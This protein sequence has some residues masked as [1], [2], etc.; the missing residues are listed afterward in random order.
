ML[1]PKH[2]I[3][4]FALGFWACSENPVACFDAEVEKAEVFQPIHFQNCSA[5]SDQY[6]WDFGDG[7]TSTDVNP[8]HAFSDTGLFQVQLM[9]ISDFGG[10]QD[11]YS[12]ELRIENPSAKF[13]GLYQASFGPED[14]LL[15]IEA[16]GSRN[17]L[18][19]FLDGKIF[20]N[21]SCFENVIEVDQQNFWTVEYVTII[22]G[23]GA[24]LESQLE[25]DFLVQDFEGNED[26]LSI[27]ANRINL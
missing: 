12:Q 24:L 16:G 2:I 27:S 7:N 22:S 3:F 23:V 21:A 18:L 11:I 17:S 15:R 14:Y 13:V 5:D 20:C 1:K 10:S 4:L 19:L 8:V 6:E 9:A 25:I 26:L